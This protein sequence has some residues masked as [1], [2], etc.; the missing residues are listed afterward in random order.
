MPEEVIQLP[1]YPF[2]EKPP[3]YTDESSFNFNDIFPKKKCIFIT[4]ILIIFIVC[5]L[6][7]I[8]ISQLKLK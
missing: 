6:I 2:N 4:F 1:D 8:I 7:L 5:P 3:S